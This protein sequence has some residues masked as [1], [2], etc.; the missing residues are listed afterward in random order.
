MSIYS[1]HRHAHSVGWSIWHFQWCTKYRHNIFRTPY[2][3]KLCEILILEVAKKNNIHVID[4]EVDV[5]HIHVIV[6]LPLCVAPPDALHQ[7]KGVTSKALFVLAPE[8]K[9]YYWQK[10]GLRSLWSSGKF[11]ASV[12]HITIEKAKRY[13][14]AHHA[15][16]FA[17]LESPL[18]CVTKKLNS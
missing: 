16:F 10:K 17:S 9:K 6:S 12:G 2:L 1:K 7:L 5:N 15:K 18:F 11:V 8:L 4:L 13:L 3:K 14:E